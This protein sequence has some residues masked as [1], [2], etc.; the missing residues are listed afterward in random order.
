MLLYKKNQKKRK[1]N[2]ATAVL[3][4]SALARFSRRSSSR[5]IFFLKKKLISKQKY[6]HTQDKHKPHQNPK[7]CFHYY[8]IIA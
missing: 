3:L 7:K 5:T 4:C 8:S 1:D 2:F 6:E